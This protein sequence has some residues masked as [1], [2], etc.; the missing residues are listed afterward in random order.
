MIED[1]NPEQQ[2]DEE[3]PSE[4]SGTTDDDGGAERAGLGKSGSEDKISK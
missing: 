1:P 4:G 3:S 2:D